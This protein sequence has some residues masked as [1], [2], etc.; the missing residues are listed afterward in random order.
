[1]LRKVLTVALASAVFLT[2]W[3]AD[4]ALRAA[5]SNGARSVTMTVCPSDAVSTNGC[6]LALSGVSDQTQINAML[7]TCGS[8]ADASMSA[9]FNATLSG[10]TLTINSVTSGALSKYM[11]VSG[12]S[13]SWTAA[14]YY[15][16]S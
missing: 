3:E 8:T 5:T 1:M 7:A 6:D 4:A 15:F 10:T 9:T 14:T 13:G 12:G 2:A 11:L 16:A